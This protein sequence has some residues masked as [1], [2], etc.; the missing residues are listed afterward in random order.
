VAKQATA[1]WWQA[2]TK[3]VFVGMIFIALNILAYIWLTAPAGQRILT[4]LQA[5]AAPGAFL[6]MLIANATVIV[7]IPWPAILIP[8]ARQSS[9]LTIVIFAGAFGSVIGESVAFFIG[10]SGRGV[11]EQSRLYSWVRRQ[12]EHPWRAFA[13]L[14]T[15]SVPPNPFFDIAGITAGAMGLPFW[16]FFTAVFLARLIRLWAI[17]TFAGALGL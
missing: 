9:N 2:W 10:R 16:L 6:V 13:V 4:S 14:F 5:Y 8:I 15:L 17:I 7:P 1:P 3:P 11:V 12:L